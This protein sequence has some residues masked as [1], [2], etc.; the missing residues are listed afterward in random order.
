MK[1][2]SIIT[3][4]Y[5]AERYIAETIESVLN[6]TAVL[7]GKAELEY[8]ICDSCS[9]DKT[10]EIIESF[11]SNSIT[12]ISEPDSGVYDALSKGLKNVSGDIVA[13]LNAGD[14]YHKC[15]FNIVLDIFEFKDVSWLTGFN[16]FYNE[17]SYVIRVVLPYKYRKRLFACGYYGTKLPFVQQESTFWSIDLNSQLDYEYLAKLSYAGDYYLWL[18]FSKVQD[19]KIVEA[20]LGGF[21]CHRGQLSENL[22]EYFTE[23]GQMT[24]KPRIQDAVLSSFDKLL[25]YAP[26]NVKKIVN[27]DNFFQ[28]SH[29]LQKWV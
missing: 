13:Y 26:S 15:A 16:F 28:F 10:L 19:L 6:Q 2:I 18:Q 9:T 5:N 29:R 22:S 21:R 20:Y 14:Y 23:L 1:K 27:N 3:P 12:V 11:H 17:Q 4:C 8:L 25:W 7:S 24:T